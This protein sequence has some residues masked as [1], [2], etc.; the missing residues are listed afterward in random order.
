MR[1]FGF[2]LLVLN[3][4]WGQKLGKLSVFNQVLTILDGLLCGLFSFLDYYS[5]LQ[6]HFLQVWPKASWLSGL[7]IIDK[8]V[9]FLGIFWADCGSEFCFCIWSGH[10]F[11]LYLV[12]HIEHPGVLK[13]ESKEACRIMESFISMKGACLLLMCRFANQ[14]YQVKIHLT[15]NVGQGGQSDSYIS[16]IAWKLS[17]SWTLIFESGHGPSSFVGNMVKNSL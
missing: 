7:F 12:S 6:S 16:I 13:S 4:K 15:T 5:R 17:F 9:G 14:S 8:V 11:F 3:W 10:Y 2:L 1:I